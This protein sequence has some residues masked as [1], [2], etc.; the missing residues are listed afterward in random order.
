M[1]AN[2][3]TMCSTLPEPGVGD[4][5]CMLSPACLV[6]C[7]AIHPHTH[8]S[9][10]QQPT[11]HTN[12]HIRH[13]HTNPRVTLTHTFVTNTPSHASHIYLRHTKSFVARTHVSHTATHSACTQGGAATC[14][15]APMQAAPGDAA[16]VAP[17][18]EP[19]LRWGGHSGSSY[20]CGPTA[21][22]WHWGRPDSG[23]GHR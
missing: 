20:P 8:S 5:R 3:T 16:A 18:P 17:C 11:R 9:Q 23:R 1:H 10:T 7:Q 12:I 2:P 13:K 22:A 14:M 15:G 21:S 19:L 6:P 4:A